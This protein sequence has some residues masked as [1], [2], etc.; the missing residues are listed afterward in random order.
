[1]IAKE[2][3]LYLTHLTLTATDRKMDWIGTGEQWLKVITQ[4][5]HE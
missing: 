5:Y 2:L 1:M 3:L 4:P